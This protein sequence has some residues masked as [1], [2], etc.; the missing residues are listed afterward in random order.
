MQLNTFDAECYSGEDCFQLSTVGFN[1]KY[2][3]YSWEE[4]RR[5]REIKMYTDRFGETFTNL[6]SDFWY[7]PRELTSADCGINCSDCQKPFHYRDG[8]RITKTKKI[9]SGGFGGGP[10]PFPDEGGKNE[11]FLFSCQTDCFR[12]ELASSEKCF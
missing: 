11:H 3:L 9:G 1:Y 7:S 10:F 8:F 12:N 2:T 6:S 4:Q 5:K